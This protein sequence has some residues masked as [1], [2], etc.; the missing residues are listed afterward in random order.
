[1]HITEKFSTAETFQ[2]GI[3]PVTRWENNDIKILTLHTTKNK[4]LERKYQPI[5]EAYGHITL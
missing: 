1:M 5:R 2:K 4:I 3:T